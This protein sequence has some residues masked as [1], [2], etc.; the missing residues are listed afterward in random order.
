MDDL[1]QRRDAAYDRGHTVGLVL[2]A[3]APMVIIY[4][5]PH[6]WVANP[7]LGA[8]LLLGH[9]LSFLVVPDRVARF[10]RDRVK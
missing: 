10:Y 1:K 5:A 3:L 6:F 2:C 9:M 7:L 4:A 8:L